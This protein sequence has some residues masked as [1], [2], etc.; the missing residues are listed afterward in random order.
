MCLRWRREACFKL[1]LELLTTHH[2]KF[3]KT[4]HT[5]PRV[6]FGVLAVSSMRC[7]LW[8]LHSE[9]TIWM[10]CAR[11]FAKVFTHQSQQLTLLILFRWWELVSSKHLIR[12]LI[13]L[14]SCQWLVPRTTCQI[15]SRKWSQYLK[16][17]RT[18]AFLGQLKSRETWAKLQR[19]F[20]R[21]STT[22]L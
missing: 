11:K 15:H 6:T 2:Q 19:G 3:G 10:A 17:V 9:P 5:I 12:D 20:L 4:S 8:I 18:L 14:K 22:I 16:S 7:V 13:V 1:K 21:Q